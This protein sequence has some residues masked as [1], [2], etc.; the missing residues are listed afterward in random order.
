VWFPPEGEATAHTVKDIRT[1]EQV[2]VDPETWL[3]PEA[4]REIRLFLRANGD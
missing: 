3:P 2:E 1:A 4:D